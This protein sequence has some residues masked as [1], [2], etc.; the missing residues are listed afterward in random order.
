MSE[1][2]FDSIFDAIS[3]SPEEAD[4]M[5]ARAA[6]R[7]AAEKRP[8]GRPVS[9]SPASVVLPPIRVT[10]DQAIRY[11]TAA[12]RDGRSLSAWIKRLADGHS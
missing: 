10:P 8:R 1:K 2:R 9:A 6:Q 5:K 7:R 4:G 11:R 12:K 3:D